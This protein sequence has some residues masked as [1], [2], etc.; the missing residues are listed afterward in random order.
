MAA[1]LTSYSQRFEDLYL[2]RCF[3]DQETGFYIDV[4]SGH[5]VYDNVSFAFYLKGWR[6]ITVE[7]NPRLAELTRAVRPRDYHYQGIVG[8]AAGQAPFYVVHDF[9]GFSTA[10][11]ANAQSALT[12]FGK[13]SEEIQVPVTTLSALCEQH[14]ATTIDFLK[15]DVEGAEAEVL[16]SGDWERFRPRIV[17][18]EALA[19]YTQLPAWEGFEPFLA[20]HGYRSVW[21]DSLNRYYLSDEASDLQR[22]FVDPIPAENVNLF[23]DAGPA[24][25]NPSHPDHHLAGLLAAGMLTRLP[26]LDGAL[27]VELLTTDM[28]QPELSRAANKD[29]V[30]NICLRV[31]GSDHLPKEMA[32]LEV[33]GMTIAD[34]YLRLVTSDR[35]RAACGRIAAGYAW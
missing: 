4:G 34:V 31:L 14:A 26:L 19:P 9:H 23:R 21:F 6:G 18:V 3:G 32:A 15:V 1:R 29:D 12:E 30:R 24:L 22:H 17:V 8:A 11:V 28:T 27:V 35:F 10:N 2:L 33:D 5:P 13:T 16:M 7:P 25:A 20:D